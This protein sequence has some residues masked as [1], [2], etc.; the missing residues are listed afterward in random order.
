MIACYKEDM[1]PQ[2]IMTIDPKKK[3]KFLFFEEETYDVRGVICFRINN[4]FLLWKQSLFNMHDFA[5]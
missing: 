3:L 5:T 1:K 2:Q 4:F